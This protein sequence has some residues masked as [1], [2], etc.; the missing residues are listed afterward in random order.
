LKPGKPVSFGHVRGT[1]W[2]GL[3]GNPLSSLV[4]WHLFGTAL[5]AALA[6]RTQDRVRRRH[7][8]LSRGLHHRPGRCE[9]R[10][11]RLTG[12]DGSGH[13]VV[14]FPDTTHSGRVAQLTDMDGL[15]LIPADAA[16]L[17]RG[18]LVEFQPF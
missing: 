16:T 2:L 18:A 7:V 9:F 1:Y 4:T 12:C 3:P 14:D 13:E 15:L 8:L 11:A 10:L 6:G 5:I 17:P